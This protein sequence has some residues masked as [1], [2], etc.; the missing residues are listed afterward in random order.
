M[1]GGMRFADG[2]EDGAASAAVDLVAA[3][4]D[5]DVSLREVL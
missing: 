4:D 3:D 2:A 5:D 1:N